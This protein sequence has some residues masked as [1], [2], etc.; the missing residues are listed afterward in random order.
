MFL[1]VVPCVR[2]DMR[3][4]VALAAGRS[5]FRDARRSDFLPSGSS[6]VPIVTINDAVTGHLI[7]R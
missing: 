1:F 5:V 2:T 4:L 6:P 3:L 7:S